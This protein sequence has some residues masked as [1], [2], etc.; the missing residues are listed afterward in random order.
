MTPFK[1]IMNP[2]LTDIIE[3]LVLRFAPHIE[4]II[5]D[6]LLFFSPEERKVILKE[7]NDYFDR[8]DRAIKDSADK[9]TRVIE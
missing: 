5:I 7:V 6:I 1:K 8:K 3:D 2:D 9:L 4:D